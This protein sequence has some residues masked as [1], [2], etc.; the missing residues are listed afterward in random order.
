[1]ED[2]VPAR[3]DV[4]F[5]GDDGTLLSNRLVCQT[6]GLYACDMFIAST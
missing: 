4:Y 6:A 2:Y 1:M 5:T 3:S